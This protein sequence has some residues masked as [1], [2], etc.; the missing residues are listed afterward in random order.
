MSLIDKIDLFH[1]LNINPIPLE[2]SQSL[3]TTE[4]LCHMEKTLNQIIEFVNNIKITANE[5]TDKQITLIKDLIEIK[6]N[7]LENLINVAE[8]NSKNYTDNQLEILTTMF[9]KEVENINALMITIDSTL[10]D[11]GIEI[12][13]IRE[14]VNK[15]KV[16]VINPTTG[17][18][19]SLQDALNAL[20]NS[21]R[22]T[23]T[24]EEVD[25]IGL[26]WEEVENLTAIWSSIEYD[27]TNALGIE[28]A[29]TTLQNNI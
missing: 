19:G 29:T 5:Y 1:G 22:V 18:H 24:W 21:I 11:M 4:M 14:I 12:K 16:V 10:N 28:V 6:V 2:F 15:G 7:A 23:L 9:N 8:L 25:A 26:T 3:T 27:V 20:Y 17:Q 13:N